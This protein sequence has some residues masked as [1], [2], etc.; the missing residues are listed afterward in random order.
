MK[1]T[2]MISALVAMAAAATMPAM[3]KTA[4][5]VSVPVSNVSI[6]QDG[7]TMNIALTLDASQV[8]SLIH[9]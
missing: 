9:I 8:L 6:A 1:T 7:K 2:A 3:A 4:V 5:P